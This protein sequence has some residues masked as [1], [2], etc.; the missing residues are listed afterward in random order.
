MNKV[1]LIVFDMAGT[2]VHDEMF[3]SKAVAAAMNEF[4]YNVQPKEVQPIMGYEKPLAIKMLLEKHEPVI[5]KIS[6]ELIEDIHARFVDI[7]MHF[8]KTSPDVR[9]I[10]GVEEVLMQIRNWGI[11]IGLDTGFSKDIANLIVERLGWLQKGL[12]QY[13]VASDEVPIGRPEPYMIYKMMDAAGI[14]DVKEVIK[15]GDTEVDVNEGK[16]ANCLYSIA[17]T[18][19]AYSRE[20]LE[21]YKPD[22]I[23]ESLD[24][25]LLIIQNHR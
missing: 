20:S 17:V 19:G 4:G 5:N 15:V 8:Y 16:N 13:V 14:T 6:N 11:L 9:P 21:K 25:L 1:K 3:V 2:T 24:E 10:D 23:L 12:V 7:M 22:F 18:T